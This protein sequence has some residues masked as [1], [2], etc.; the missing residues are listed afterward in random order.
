MDEH[1][2]SSDSI[3]VVYVIVIFSFLPVLSTPTFFFMTHPFPIQFGNWIHLFQRVEFSYFLFSSEIRMHSLQWG[4][5]K[6]NMLLHF[7]F[8]F[9]LCFQNSFGFLFTWCFLEPFFFLTGVTILNGRVLYFI[10]VF[11]FWWIINI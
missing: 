8:Y 7:R 3:S 4:F 6:I 5:V 11:V 9:L 1:P 10:N 2:P